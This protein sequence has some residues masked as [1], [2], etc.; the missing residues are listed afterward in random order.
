MR[1]FPIGGLTG[2][3]HRFLQ[4]FF[5]IALPS[6]VP[7]HKLQPPLS[8][9]PLV[10]SSSAP[11]ELY[12]LLAFSSL[13]SLVQSSEN[14]SRQEAWMVVGLTVF[15]FHFSV[16]YCS[17]SHYPT[18]KNMC[19]RVRPVSQPARLLMTRLSRLTWEWAFGLMETLSHL[20]Q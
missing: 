11:W 5:W 20:A 16:L 12:V 3:L 13:V 18:S 7:L 19:T 17:A 2:Q 15:V 10:S 1:G 14:V 9:R 6:V 4:L 8:P